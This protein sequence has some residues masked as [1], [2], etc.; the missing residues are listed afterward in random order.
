M[1]AAEYQ[2]HFGEH[3]YDE[4]GNYIG[5]ADDAERRGG[6]GR[7]LR[8]GRPGASRSRAAPPRPTPPAHAEAGRRADRGRRAEDAAEAADGRADARRAPPRPPSRGR[9][10]RAAP[11]TPRSRPSGS[12]ARTVELPTARPARSG[13]AEV[14]SGRNP[15]CE[16]AV[17]RQR[18]VVGLTG[19]GAGPISRKRSRRELSPDADP[20]RGGRRRRARGVRRCSGTSSGVEDEANDNAER[21]EVFVVKQTS[22]RAPPA[23]RPC[24]QG[25]IV[26]DE[27]PKEFLPAD[28][29]HRP[30]R[31]RRQGGRHRPR[32]QPG[33]RRAACSSTRRR[34]VDRDRLEQHHRR[35]PGRRHASRS[36]RPRRRRPARPR[37]PRQ[38]HGRPTTARTATPATVRR[39][40]GGDAASGPPSAVRRSLGNARY[41]YQKVQIL[42]VDQT[43]WLS[44]ARSADHRRPTAPPTEPAN[45]GLLTF[46]RA[47]R[48]P[49]SRSPRS[50]PAEHLPDARAAGTTSPRPLP[51]DRP[52]RRRCPARTPAQLTPYGPTGGRQSSGRPSYLGRSHLRVEDD[53]R[54]ALTQPTGPRPVAVVDGRPDRPRDRLGHAARRARRRRFAIDRGARASDLDRRPRSWSCSAR[55]APAPTGCRAPSSLLASRTARSGAILVADE[56]DHR[57]APA[58][59][60]RRRHATCSPRRSTPS[61]LGR[62]GR[63][64]SSDAR[65]SLAASPA[66]DAVAP[67]EADGD[68][69][70][71]HHRVLH[72]GRR[73]QVGGRHQPR[74]SSLAKRTE[75]AGRARRRRPPVR[76]RRGDAQAGAAA[77]DRRRRRLARPARRRRCCRAC[78]MRHEPS[79]LLV[80]PGA[81][82]AGVRRPDRRGRD[83]ADRRAAAH[84]LQPTSSSTR[85]A[86]FNDVV[87]G[88]I[89]ESD[90]VLLVAGMDIPNIKNVKIGLQTLRLL[91]TP[92]SKLHLVLNR[93][94]SKVKL[95]VSEVE[96]TL[97]VKAE[98]LDPERR[99]R[100][101]V[102]EQGHAGRPRRAEV[103][104][105]PSRIEQLADMF[106]ADDAAGRRQATDDESKGR[107]GCRLYKRL[108]EVQ[109]GP[110]RRRAPSV[111]T[112]CSTSCARRS[113]TTSST[114]WARSSTTSG[115]RE[116]D[117]RRRVHEQLHA[118]LAQE[119]APLSAADKAQL[120][121]DVSD[122]ILGYGPIDRLLKDDERH[123]GHGQRPD[124]GLRRAQ[125]ASIERDRRQLRRRDPPPAHHRQDR[126]PGRPAHRRGDADG[127]RPPPR[128]LP[129]ERGHPPAGHRR[130]VPHHPEVLQGP[131]PGRRPDPLRHAQR[132]TSARFLQACV[133][134]PPERHRLRRYRHRQDDDAQ[135]AVVVHPRRRAHRHRRGRQ[136]AP[137]PPGPR[138]RAW[139]PARRT[140][141]A[142]A[143]SRSA[144]SCATPCA[145]APT[146]SSSASAVAARPSTCSRP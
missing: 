89:E 91:N 60:P 53:A 142:R 83:G 32:G 131:V 84:V 18:T 69:R 24:G 125:R 47:R 124:I 98:S 66:P 57:P 109:Q 15:G 64:A 7:V 97:Q 123:R 42:A 128:R 34:V 70:P 94:N 29:D 122:D 27:I 138:A 103:A 13:G 87:L 8:R 118:A 58:G 141:R 6:L 61:Q 106:V 36:T 9:R 115:C 140:S 79:G 28:G 21:V 37:R 54:P 44:P 40:R 143:R 93:A 133:V 63:A 135:R 19:P 77:H 59:A 120:I 99:R 72:Q 100:A 20:D 41:L 31:A 114:S 78:S 110:P 92:M 90:D 139:R 130:A 43:R 74:P 102:G 17:G 45:C 107:S 111:A 55:R 129:C 10:D 52:D 116:D 50:T 88:L 137:A 33:H 96:R 113:T 146:A 4:Q 76:R 16:A 126:G 25:C 134:G 56:L 49:R 48:R 65:R 22:P 5:A 86:Y 35:A 38:P 3:A 68:A 46:D 121:Q 23:R 127:R 145:C 119:R 51:A 144:T 73:R 82:R 117:L 14:R 75:Q 2:E 80:L 105:S 26:K 62:G 85:P 132:R 81:A 108:H 112:R 30:D 67:R 104:V 12:P 95:D 101:A 71:G 39:R 11:T 136:G 1:V